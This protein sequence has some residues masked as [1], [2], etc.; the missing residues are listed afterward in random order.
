MEVNDFTANHELFYAKA[1]PKGES[2]GLRALL[3]MTMELMQK[4]TK[5]DGAISVDDLHHWDSS[6]DAISFLSA[7]I[8]VTSGAELLKVRPSILQNI[9]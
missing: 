1:K 3:I 7:T 9:P 6:S 2:H 8:S 4:Y 5:E